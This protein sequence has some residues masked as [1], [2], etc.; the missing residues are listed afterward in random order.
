ML[1]RSVLAEQPIPKEGIFYYEVTITAEKTDGIYIGLAKKETPLG[2]WVGSD[3]STYGYGS[4]GEFW[5]LKVEGCSYWDGRPYTEGKP[6]FEFGKGDVIG[7]GVNLKTRKKIYTKNGQPLESAD[8]LLAN[9]DADLFPSVS[10]FYPGN[11]IEA[12]FGPDFKI[13]LPEAFIK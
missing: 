3:E 1:D 6:E 12:N 8:L 13:T 4:D 7:C 11:K 9:P 2:R 5:G 10:L